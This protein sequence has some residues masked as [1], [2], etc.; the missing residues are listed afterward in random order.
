MHDTQGC[1]QR[2]GLSQR[3]LVGE[4]APV[5]VVLEVRDARGDE[6]DLALVHEREPGGAIDELA[7]DP[8]PERG[9]RRRLLA[10]RARAWRIMRS[11]AGLQKLPWVLAPL[12]ESQ[13]EMKA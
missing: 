13:V 11:T 10:S 12:Q 2:S 7:V 5:R 1:L 3:E 9:G 8:C 6:V 4:D